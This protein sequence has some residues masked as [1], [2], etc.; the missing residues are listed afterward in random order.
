MSNDTQGYDEVLASLTPEMID[1]FR[2]ALELGKW[3]DGRVLT[4]EQKAT[5]LQAVMVWEAN[6]LPEAERT[7][8][9]ERN[10]CQSNKGEED[11]VN[12]S[13]LLGG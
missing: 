1:R 9:I 12:I 7:G 5:T 8:Y 2:T 13:D 4:K 10:A 3:P 11:T 6:N